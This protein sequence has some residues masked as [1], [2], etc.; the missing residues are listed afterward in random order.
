[1][2]IGDDDTRM[3]GGAGLPDLEPKFEVLSE[4]GRG[5]MGSVYRV[6]HRAMDRERAVKVLHVEMAEG[7]PEFFERFRREAT[8]A[9]DLSHPPS[10]PPP[11]RLSER[12]GRRNRRDAETRL[13]GIM[14][15][16]C[17]FPT[18]EGS[19]V[20]NRRRGAADAFAGQMPG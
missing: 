3:S 10:S 15:N 1:M 18:Q 5:G 20:R 19:D 13:E 4:L 8:I 2:A 16:A 14:T 9:S 11:S 7:R 12:R 6:R 17:P